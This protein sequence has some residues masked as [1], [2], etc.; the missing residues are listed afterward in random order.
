M[1]AA[2]TGRLQPRLTRGSLLALEPVR[3]AAEAATL[4]LAAPVLA[5]APR[6][7]GRAVLV[8]PGFGADDTSTI[9]LRN[10]LDLL[11]YRSRGWR[12][13]RNAGARMLDAPLRD[14]L[15]RLAD[16]YGPVSLVGWS[17]GGVLARRLALET[18]DAIRDVITLASPINGLVRDR[19]RTLSVIS[20]PPDLPCTSIYS[21]SDAIVHAEMSIEANYPNT[22]NIEVHASHSGMGFNPTVYFAMADRL[23]APLIGRRPFTPPPL[24]A[25]LYP[26]RQSH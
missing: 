23:A 8:L 5:L 19:S 7:D 9:G 14:R 3:M 21:R 26:R 13:G 18:P 4:P 2:R 16:R 12:L 22:E 10:Y 1:Q 11:G 15:A 17:Y 25:M 20:Q 24:L 6:G